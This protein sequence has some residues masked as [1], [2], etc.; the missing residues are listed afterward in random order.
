M[1]ETSQSLKPIFSDGERE[2]ILFIER[3]H[4]ENGKTPT[5]EQIEDYL[6]AVGVLNCNLAAL[7]EDPRFLQS[8]DV[9]GIDIN[10][11][12]GQLS[13]KQ[14]AAVGI[15]MSYIDRRSDEK[16]LR[17]LGLS[18]KEWA[19]W[20]QDDTFAQYVNNYSERLIANSTHEAHMGLIRS[21]RSGN[22]ASIKLYYE[23]TGRH[24]D[25]KDNVVDTKLLIYKIIEIIQKYEKDPVILT[26]MSTDMMELSAVVDQIQQPKNLKG[27]LVR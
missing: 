1:T 5:D 11:K 13:A 27:Q 21:M 7:K 4:S 20:L 2:V 17:D 10:L 18:P 9:R 24:S 25:T 15:M 14:M 23:L 26:K 12:Y 3:Y 8:M 19:A 22:T 16:K 6:S